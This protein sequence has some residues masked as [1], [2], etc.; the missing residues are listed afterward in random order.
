MNRVIKNIN[1]INDNKTEVNCH[2]L[3]AYFLLIDD[4]QSAIPFF[5]K[6]LEINDKHIDSLLNIGACYMK[7][8]KFDTAIEYFETVL[9]L[10]ENDQTFE[11]N[12]KNNRFLCYM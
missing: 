4:P 11:L 3:G 12:V 2:F 8:G 6:A 5:K 7:S 9:P 1:V 10:I